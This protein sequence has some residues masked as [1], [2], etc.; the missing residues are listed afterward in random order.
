[1][2]LILNYIAAGVS[3]ELG[4]SRKLDLVIMDLVMDN[5][6]ISGGKM[7]IHLVSHVIYQVLKPERTK[8]Y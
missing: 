7:E 6:G 3:Q 2:S 1:M 5:N 8:S 4:S